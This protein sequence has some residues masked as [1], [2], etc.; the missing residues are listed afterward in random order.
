MTFKCLAFTL[1][2]HTLGM[3]VGA[4]VEVVNPRGIKRVPDMPSFIAGVVKIRGEMVPMVDMRERVGVQPLPEKER[5][6]LVRSSGG[7]VGLIV[8]GV[9][10][11]LRFEHDMLRKPP[12]MFHGLK[13]KYMA[14]LYGDNDNPVIVLDIDQIL[15]SDEKIE[16]ERAKRRIEKKSK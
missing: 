4:V 11:I 16:L 15:S 8:D 3:D 2:A 1:G 6:V 14:G 12:V 5:A 10:G 13:R 7:K 9:R